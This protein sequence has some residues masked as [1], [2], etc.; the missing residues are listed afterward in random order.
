MVVSPSLDAHFMELLG[1]VVEAYQQVH[2]LTTATVENPREWV[3]MGPEYA[4]HSAY[5]MD[6]Q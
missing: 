3:Q 6:M 2:T 4:L 1:A 5:P